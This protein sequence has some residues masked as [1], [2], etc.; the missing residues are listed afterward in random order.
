MVCA[1][2]QRAIT[3]ATIDTYHPIG[4]NQASSTRPMEFFGIKERIMK[5]QIIDFSGNVIKVYSGVNAKYESQQYINKHQNIRLWMRD[6]SGVS[7]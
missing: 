4:G 5:Y 1:A 6:V 7:K 3:A 2:M